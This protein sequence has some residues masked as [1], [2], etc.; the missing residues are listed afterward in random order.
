MTWDFEN[1][2]RGSARTSIQGK[3]LLAR[4]SLAAQTEVLG[5]TT[6]LHSWHR[7][8]HSP[9]KHADTFPALCVFF[10]LGTWY[11]LQVLGA[12]T[13]VCLLSFFEEDGETRF[14]F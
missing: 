11:A 14:Y 13:S 2:A 4:K 12:S 1:L 6:E 8:P 5:V 7:T 3:L 10:C 9:A